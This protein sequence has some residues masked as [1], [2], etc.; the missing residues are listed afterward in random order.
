MEIT[1][2]NADEWTPEHEGWRIVVRAKRSPIA[3]LELDGKTVANMSRI[4][5]GQWNLSVFHCSTDPR[6]CPHKWFAGAD[7][8]SPVDGVHF[9]A[10]R[11]AEGFPLAYVDD[12]GTHAFYEAA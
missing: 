2:I 1:T 8:A 5:E 7:F 11:I 9:I 3:A 6:V 12:K 10:N 4:R